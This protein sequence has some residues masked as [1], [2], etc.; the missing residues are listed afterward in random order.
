MFVRLEAVY[1]IVRVCSRT[2]EELILFVLVFFVLHTLFVGTLRVCVFM[3]VC[4]CM[5]VCVYVRVRVCICVYVC[6]CVCV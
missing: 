2:K 5:C 6:V 4:L 1:V 3:Y